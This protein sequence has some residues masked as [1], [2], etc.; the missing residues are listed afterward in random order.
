MTTT[1]NWN[2]GAD[3]Y[4]DFKAFTYNGDSRCGWYKMY[5]VVAS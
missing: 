4:L 5:E 3:V 2:I 1:Y